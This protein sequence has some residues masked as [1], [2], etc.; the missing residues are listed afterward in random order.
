MILL[1]PKMFVQRYLETRQQTVAMNARRSA[2]SSS[3]LPYLS[4]FVNIQ[5]LYVDGPIYGISGTSFL[6]DAEKVN[7]HCYKQFED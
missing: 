2:Q 7:K 1:I 6:K 4:D 3:D 5:K